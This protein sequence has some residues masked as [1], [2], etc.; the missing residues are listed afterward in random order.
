MGRLDRCRR[1]AAVALPCCLPPTEVADPPLHAP[2]LRPVAPVPGLGRLSSPHSLSL[3]TSVL[4]PYTSTSTTTHVTTN[5]STNVSP[6]MSPHLPQ[7]SSPPPQAGLSWL[8]CS[9]KHEQRECTAS[10]PFEVHPLNAAQKVRNTRLLATHPLAH[11][12]S[13]P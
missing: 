8:P 3:L 6:P 4:L 12:I 13:T 2:K 7:L 5:V 9:L 11:A 10:D 1:E